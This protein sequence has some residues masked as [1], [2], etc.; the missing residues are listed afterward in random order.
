MS[1]ILDLEKQL[2]KDVANIKKLAEEANLD[3]FPV[4]F[5][6]ITKKAMVEFGTYALPNRY[7][8]WTFGKD[9]GRLKNLSNLGVLEI[10]EMVLNADPATAFLLDSNTLVEHQMVIAHVFA[11][12]DFFKN[13]Y[14][15]SK[16]N[17]NMINE[18]KF[19]ER[20]IQELENE[21]GKKPVEE[22]IDVCLSIQWHVDFYEVFK[23]EEQQIRVLSSAD[24]SRFNMSSD[25]A[26]DV[27][28]ASCPEPPEDETN[29]SRSAYEAGGQT[30]LEDS[31]TPGR[32]PIISSDEGAAASS[33]RESG[34][35]KQASSF[36]DNLC[37]ER[38]LLK[39]LM[40][41]APLEDWQREILQI[42][43]D[44]IIYFAPTSLTKIMNEGWATYW[45]TELCQKYL[46]FEDFSQF[47]VK[48]SE[49]M[50]SKGMNPYKIGFM[51]YEDLK[52]R[53]DEKD[54]EGA[55]LKKI[56]EVRRFEDDVSFIRNYLTQDICDKC[57]LFLFEQD[58]NTGEMVITSTNV[59]DI[60]S[61]IINELINFGKP[62]IVVRDYD[63]N[64]N[65]E[66]YMQHK[67]DGRELDMEYAIDVMKAMYR[68]WKRSIHLET[69]R[70][71]KRLLVSYNGD[72]PELR[73]I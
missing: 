63:Y 23:P 31:P 40:R 21:H 22:F 46:D 42:V 18:A 61:S 47:A 26:A 13:N 67:Y 9:Y 72:K 53:W 59:E 36:S 51:I 10:L 2:K 17:R 52:N 38:D 62:V 49:L 66:L 8:H 56:F 5:E 60:K 57:G 41:E 55:G 12:C 6:V 69:I 33:S 73:H 34:A 29:G 30:K 19:H 25:I 14:W 24:R 39:F 1:E 44:E 4:N 37:D 64:H 48:H 68:T 11:H 54:G 43:H 70:D 16:T 3:F 65:R 7:S 45:H 35:G 50:S 20:R 58:G 32:G 27:E 71:D 15:F 28:A